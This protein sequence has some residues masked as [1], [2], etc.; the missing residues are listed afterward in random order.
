MATTN[1][2]NF[3]GR[4]GDGAFP[5]PGLVMDAAGNLYGTTQEGGTHGPYACYDYGCGTIFKLT[6][7]SDGTWTE[8]IAH[9]FNG[10]DGQYPRAALIQDTA[11]KPL[12]HYLCRRSRG[13]RRGLR[14]HTV[15]VRF[16]RQALGR[17]RLGTRCLPDKRE[18]EPRISGNHSGYVTSDQVQ[19]PYS[20]GL[21]VQTG[22]Q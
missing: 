18:P 1:L 10:A 13:Q 6:P 5:N 14:A 7:S 11:R 15:S 12:R 2:Y 4:N 21:A 9:T 17:V 8:S 3:T 20:D 19:R 22:R 16:H